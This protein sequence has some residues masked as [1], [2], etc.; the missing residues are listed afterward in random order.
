[1][2]KQ[3]QKDWGIHDSPSDVR[4]R[5]R[6]KE[7]SRSNEGGFKPTKRSSGENKRKQ[8][9]RLL[10]PLR[11]PPAPMPLPPRKIDPCE[12]L[13]NPTV[14][15]YDLGEGVVAEVCTD[16][17]GELGVRFEEFPAEKNGYDVW[18]KRPD[19]FLLLRFVQWEKFASKVPVPEMAAV[20]DVIWGYFSPCRMNLAGG[21]DLKS[22]EKKEV[23]VSPTPAKTVTF[24]GASANAT[25][26]FRSE[27]GKYAFP[28]EG[29]GP[30]ALF[31]VSKNV[32]GVAV[33]TFCGAEE[34][35]P[36]FGVLAPLTLTFGHLFEGKHIPELLQK[37]G[38][39][40]I[41][42]EL[43]RFKDAMSRSRISPKVTLSEP[44]QVVRSDR[45]GVRAP[46]Y[47]H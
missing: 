12:L 7:L 15:V 40:R 25:R 19:T 5:E 36:L 23:S 4:R 46:Q 14:G 26:F 29:K 34:G 38:A 45:G 16:H 41:R 22:K 8:V 24:E 44:C 1:M 6:I 37:K 17:K 28:P 3:K 27:E 30:R 32:Q 21:G 9:P 47:G 13:Q 31:E 39:E 43:G 42:G 20:Q 18:L 11:L 10:D 35:N 2:A 33:Y